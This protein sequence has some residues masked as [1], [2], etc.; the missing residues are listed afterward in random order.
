[1]TVAE[2]EFE[3]FINLSIGGIRRVVGV[4]RISS[5]LSLISL[6]T[7]ESNPRRPKR[8]N[9]VESIRSEILSGD[10]LFTYKSRGLLVGAEN[11]VELGPGR[12]E[13]ELVDQ[14]IEG[15]LD[16]GHN[17]LGIGLA[18]LELSTHQSAQLKNVHDW[19]QFKEIWERSGVALCE[20]EKSCKLQKND[21]LIGVEFILPEV[22]E[23]EESLAVFRRSIIDI[24][25]A[26]NSSTSLR[27]STML[28]K[29]GL[30][31]PLKVRLKPILESRVQ[32]TENGQGA[33]KADLLITKAL[34]PF[35]VLS[36]NFPILNSKG[37]R[38][39]SK[40]PTTLYA[41]QSEAINLYREF[42]LSDSLT[43]RTADYRR[44]LK[45]SQG[46]SVFD[47]A[48]EI[49]EI[50]D[51]IYGKF[52]T[53]F[54]SAGFGSLEQIESVRKFNH[55]RR[56]ALTLPMSGSPV[57]FVFPEALIQPILRGLSVL[58]RY[59]SKSQRVEWIV[60]DVY[61]FIDDHLEQIAAPIAKAF[62]QNYAETPDRFG[63]DSE[64]IVYSVV[65]AQFRRFI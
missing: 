23:D 60:D 7:L 47:I 9:I 48:A 57:K 36:E 27:S 35:T 34:V 30:L 15:I 6:A 54:N 45:S 62:T 63:K 40:S 59:N 20:W 21:L 53:A 14:T 44:I 24:C 51:Y 37:K 32:W 29:A 33:V 31:D 17:T 10:T 1:M 42:M 2:L 5:L 43:S 22:L 18:I 52:P 65:E 49:P 8:N 4:V 28:D 13:L 3:N 38:L 58:M 19:Y 26:R 50:Y 61:Q 39:V 55:R 56:N 25:A 64:Q 46:E 12:F 11:V 16:G 41:S